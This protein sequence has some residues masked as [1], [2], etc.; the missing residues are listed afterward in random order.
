MRHTFNQTA[1][2]IRTVSTGSGWASSISISSWTDVNY[3]LNLSFLWLLRWPKKGSKEFSWT[4]SSDSVFTRIK[5]M[6]ECTDRRHGSKMKT[7]PVIKMVFFKKNCPKN[8]SKLQWWRRLCCSVRHHVDKDVGNVLMLT[9][10][11]VNTVWRSVRRPMHSYMTK[12][13]P[14]W[15][16]WLQRKDC[17]LVF[18]VCPSRSRWKPGK[19]HG[20][21]QAV[22]SQNDNTLS[23]ILVCVWET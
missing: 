8:A 3:G 10:S 7:Q 6:D 11:N 16:L 21:I 1:L 17:T 14:A 2:K 19:Y 9:A 18:T 23:L 12:Q 22:S 15:A 13:G 5:R 20:S 4:H